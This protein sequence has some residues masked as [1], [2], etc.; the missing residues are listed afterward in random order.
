MKRYCY[1]SEKYFQVG[2][3]N[4]GLNFYNMAQ[5]SDLSSVHNGSISFTKRLA[6]DF[7]NSLC[8]LEDVNS[9]FCWRMASYGQV[10]SFLLR[11]FHWF[12][13]P[14]NIFQVFICVNWSYWNLLLV[15]YSS[16]I[17][18]LAFPSCKA[19]H[20]HLLQIQS[21]SRPKPLCSF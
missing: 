13:V 21:T 2:N 6:T 17:D 1:F 3:W 8:C 12:A 15:L 10:L 5:K 16:K 18:I 7:V 20:F 14:A 19:S 11:F 4:L 9:S